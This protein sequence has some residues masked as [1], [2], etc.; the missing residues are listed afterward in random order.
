MTAKL[1]ET[2]R[3]QNFVSS[4]PAPPVAI[5]L[6]ATSRNPAESLD[7]V[8][9][10]MEIIATKSGDTWLSDQEWEAALPDWFVQGTKRHTEQEIEANP[11]LWDGGGVARCNE[12]ERLGMVEFREGSRRMDCQ[13]C[14]I[15]L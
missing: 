14:S 13:S 10:V 9:E 1:T 6:R 12:T 3:L 4:E 7:R 15:M 5:C 11:K 2:Y 8:K